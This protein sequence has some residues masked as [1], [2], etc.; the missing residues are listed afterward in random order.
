MKI[1]SVISMVYK[2]LGFFCYYFA[3][4]LFIIGF[5]YDEKILNYDYLSS[6]IIIIIIG[7]FLVYWG[8]KLLKLEKK[9]L[10]YL[11]GYGYLHDKVINLEEIPVFRDIPC[12]GD[13]YY[14]YVLIK[15]N[16]FEI[17]NINLLGA[18]ILK[19]IKDGIIS[20]YKKDNKNILDFTK[21]N[22]FD[23]EF[24]Y[25]LFNMIYESSN[26]GIL[27]VNEL[28]E[29]ASN[30][31]MKFLALFSSMENNIINKLKKEFHIY[32]RINVEDCFYL[33][34]MDDKIYNDSIKL[35][36]FMK[37]L[38]EFS[39]LDKKDINDLQLWEDYMIFAT[40]FGISD[41]VNSQLKDLI[42]NV[43]DL[44]IYNLL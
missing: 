21:K 42:P 35:Y 2:V 7:I 33:Y 1:G 15:L 20:Y 11:D 12:D 22:D 36:G 31:D 25:K 26:D 43:A 44:D 18:I 39:L 27:D 40:L 28:K 9:L 32:H 5:F 23:N 10:E 29:W 6:K 41:K 16:K 17:K 30:Y 38:E 13:I 14:T 19:W 24:E 8:N 34:V 37:F 4:I 3:G